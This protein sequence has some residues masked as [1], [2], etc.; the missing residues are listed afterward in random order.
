MERL[1]ERFT[2]Y[3]KVETTAAEDSKT[4]PSTASQLELGK[5]L[6][7]ELRA[8]KLEDVEMSEHGIV[9]ATIPGTVP[10]APVMAWLAH[11]D[12]SP[13]ASGKDVKPNVIKNYDGKDIQLSGDTSKVIRV[14]ECAELVEVAVDVRGHIG[15]GPDRGIERECR[16]QPDAQ[17][18]G[19]ATQGVEVV[20]AA[21]R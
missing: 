2:R 9:T 3:V 8:L 19:E 21:V 4:Y 15:H 20:P 13:E 14:E 12:T 10:D 1:L 5:M 6:A 7:E 11:M 17:Q 18:H 16:V